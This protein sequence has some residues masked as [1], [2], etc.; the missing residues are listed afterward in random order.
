[1]SCLKMKP[2]AKRRTRSLY[3][4][5]DDEAR[6]RR[7]KIEVLKDGS[8]VSDSVLIR[9]ALIAVDT[10][11]REFKQSITFLLDER[12]KSLRDGYQRRS[13]AKK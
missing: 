3:L 1:M 11:S 7:M 4:D 13:A 9:A 2:P 8:N 5:E 6:L 10:S 12:T